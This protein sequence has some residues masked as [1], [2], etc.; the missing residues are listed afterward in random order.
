MKKI[1]L[2]LSIVFF[3]LIANSQNINN[4]TTFNAGTSF[5][6]NGIYLNA[7]FE[8]NIQVLNKE[9]YIKY[10]NNMIVDKYGYTNSVLGA[11][12]SYNY[13]HFKTLN[14]LN[15]DNIQITFFYKHLLKNNSSLSLGHG[16]ILPLNKPDLSKYN[17]KN[18]IN[19][20]GYF[21]TI[22]INYQNYLKLKNNNIY[23]N[24]WFDIYMHNKELLIDQNI[25]KFTPK[26]LIFYP[27]TFLNNI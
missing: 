9:G 25:N 20:S 3:A 24:I 23:Y 11:R 5:R 2:F 7:F 18:Y 17:N 4:T 16:T 15:N 27:L 14:E 13:L 19:F 1:I 10:L 22:N 21:V 26:I 6:T 12:L 8:K